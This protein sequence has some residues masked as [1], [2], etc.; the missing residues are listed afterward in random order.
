MYRKYLGPISFL[1]QPW[2][3]THGEGAPWACN[4]LQ[5]ALQLKLQ[6]NYEKLRET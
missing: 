6:R 4:L 2:P 5:L 3:Q 1:L